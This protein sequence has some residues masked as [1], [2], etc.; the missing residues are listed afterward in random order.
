MRSMKEHHP[1][2]EWRKANGYDQAA[3]AALVGVGASHIS[4]IEQRVRGASL[5]LASK[6]E[7]ITAIPA[8]DLRREVSQ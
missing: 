1:L 7:E 5:D 8:R 4:Q 6:I 2:R 3:F